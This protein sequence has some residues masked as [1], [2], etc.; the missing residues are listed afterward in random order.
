MADHNGLM[1]QID[2]DA[3]PTPVTHAS[4]PIS[5]QVTRNDTLVS[6]QSSDLLVEG[7][8]S[9]APLDTLEKSLSAQSEKPLLQK[10][11]N[12]YSDFKSEPSLTFFHETVSVLT[13]HLPSTRTI[14]YPQGDVVTP[15][16]TF[17]DCLENLALALREGV[18]TPCVRTWYA[19]AEN[20]EACDTNA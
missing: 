11:K 16:E 15:G 19:S 14:C 2:L 9:K 6:V 12:D 1:S 18:D 17:S 10:L 3:L 5:R 13:F 8:S 4:S 20:R 7:L